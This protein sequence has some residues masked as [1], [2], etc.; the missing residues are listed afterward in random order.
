MTG[1]FEYRHTLADDSM[2]L[3]DY[4]KERFPE[5]FEER[6]RRRGG[7]MKG[8]LGRAGS[9]FPAKQSM[10]PWSAPWTAPSARRTSSIPVPDS[11]R[12]EY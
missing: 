8:R 7:S 1:L 4:L 12:R 9:L 2:F 6:R 3:Y 10:E 5:E 11:V